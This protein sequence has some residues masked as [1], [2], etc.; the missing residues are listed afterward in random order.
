MT[1][2]NSLIDHNAASITMAG[3]G[4]LSIYYRYLDQYSRVAIH[5]FVLNIQKRNTELMVIKA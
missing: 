1:D 5:H 2:V 3:N 4:K